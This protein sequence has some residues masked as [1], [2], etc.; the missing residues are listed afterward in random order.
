MSNAVFVDQPAISPRCHLAVIMPCTMTVTWQIAP[1]LRST[2][3][4][5]MLRTAVRNDL[6]DD[7]LVDTQVVVHDLVAHPMMSVHRI[8]G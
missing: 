6:P 5:S 4:R 8:F 3:C 1:T 7:V 2:R